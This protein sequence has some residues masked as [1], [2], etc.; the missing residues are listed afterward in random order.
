[1]GQGASHEEHFPVASSDGQ[2]MGCC[3]SSERTQSVADLTG[4]AEFG[5]SS[6]SSACRPP[7]AEHGVVR[8]TKADAPTLPASALPIRPESAACSF[9]AATDFGDGEDRHLLQGIHLERSQFLRLPDSAPLRVRVGSVEVIDRFL[10]SN[11]EVACEIRLY[12]PRNALMIALFPETSYA[13]VKQTAPAKGETKGFGRSTWLFEEELAFE[14]EAVGEERRV[15][16]GLQAQV[17]L[18]DC[19]SGTRLAASSLFKVPTDS[20]QFE[21]LW[22]KATF[23]SRRIGQVS[24]ASGWIGTEMVGW[25]SQEVLRRASLGNWDWVSETVHAMSSQE[26][27]DMVESSCDAARRRI[28]DYAAMS[29]MA[30]PQAKHVFNQLLKAG[31]S[32]EG[33]ADLEGL[34]ALHYASFAG[35]CDAVE[36]LLAARAQPEVAAAGGVTPLMLAALAGSLPCARSLLEAG[37]SIAAVDDEGQTAVTWVCLGCG[38]PPSRSG[39]NRFLNNGPEEVKAMA[40][41][42]GGLHEALD[43]RRSRGGTEP[44]G[45]PDR[46]ELLGE[47]I[48]SFC[49]SAAFEGASSPSGAA[50]AR[51]WLPLLRE[52]S[53]PGPVR[54]G[55]FS[56]V[57]GKLQKNPGLYVPL[58]GGVLRASIEEGRHWGE[59]LCRMLLREA[60]ELPVSGRLS[61]G[62]PLV[63]TAFDLG[64]DEVALMLCDRGASLDINLTAQARALRAAVDSGHREIA[65]EIVG[66]WAEERDAW[67]RPA[68]PEQEGLAECPVCFRALCEAGPAVLFSSAGRR[69]CGHF[70]CCTCAAE[71]SIQSSSPRCPV[72]RQPFQPPVQRPPDPREDPA[73]WFAFFD[74]AQTGYLD[75]QLLERVLPAVV[76]VDAEQLEASLHGELWHEWDPSGEGRV[77]RRAFCGEKGL[78]RWLVEH[79]EELQQ[80][81]EK[82]PLPR[83]EV[84][85]EGWFL[86]WASAGTKLMGKAEVLRAVL[87]SCGTSSLEASAVAASREWIERCWLLW[88]RDGSGKISLKEFCAEGGLADMMLQ[89]SSLAAAKRVVRRMELETHDPAALVACCQHLVELAVGIRPEDPVDSWVAAAC[90]RL[91]ERASQPA[92]EEFEA[93]LQRGSE[94]VVL[95]MT[96]NTSSA[97]LFAWGCRALTA[98]CLPPPSSFEDKPNEPHL[99]DSKHGNSLNGS[100]GNSCDGNHLALDKLFAI[101]RTDIPEKV[102]SRSSFVLKGFLALLPKDDR[103]TSTAPPPIAPGA[104]REAGLCALAA[105]RA[106]CDREG[107]ASVTQVCQELISVLQDGDSGTAA[108]VS[109]IAA[110]IAV[111]AMDGQSLCEMMLQSMHDAFPTGEGHSRTRA[112]SLLP[113]LRGL[114]TAVAEGLKR[115][116]SRLPTAAVA[117]ELTAALLASL[118]T[119]PAAARNGAGGGASMPSSKSRVTLRDGHVAVGDVVRLHSDVERV[120]REQEPPEH[121]GGWCDRMAFCLESPGRVVEI[122]KRSARLPE[123]LRISH[124]ALGCW[125]WNAK[126]VAE[127]LP[128]AGLLPFEECDTGPGAALTIGDEVRI[129]VTVEEAKT[130]QVNHGGWNDRMSQCCGRVGRLEAIDKAGDMKVLVPGAGSFVWNPAALRSLHAQ[131][132]DLAL[133]ERLS[134][135]IEG[136]LPLTLL[137]AL[138]GLGCRLDDAGLQAALHELALEASVTQDGGFRGWTLL[139]TAALTI[140]PAMASYSLKSVPSPDK[141]TAQQHRPV[142]SVLRKEGNAQHL[143]QGE[144]IPP[145]GER[146][147]SELLQKWWEELPSWERRAR[148]V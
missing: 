54:C 133:V 105:L 98:L 2:A 110:A 122:P 96:R 123:V 5:T 57:Y 66:Q 100:G 64:W 112:V 111:L 21:P 47:L 7:K 101:I 118:R 18:I 132:W 74:E 109:W 104:L 142:R 72:C 23:T 37:A 86:H 89:Q 9:Q 77:S 144:A 61:D 45:G 141:D 95:A 63:E 92:H 145:F 13:E 12:A 106:L 1:M 20:E 138:A 117:A 80:E 28:L 26:L 103:G 11:A 29:V 65:K 50:A 126:S 46:R 75:R 41:I 40:G 8:P 131:R 42:S 116:P 39:R 19:V 102:D 4:V 55:C 119:L 15:D 48:D 107:P 30:E 10:E 121:F 79:F 84:D 25:L 6:S 83:L 14:G 81:Q 148:A 120:K 24:V 129:E 147:L 130:L 27:R 22:S 143:L 128:D 146:S 60:P 125:C 82:G 68:A 134:G 139:A 70:L 87:K 52:A 93:V 62:R 34:T 35:S 78:L 31:V 85:R 99:E 17:L 76:P 108:H 53:K 135:S 3:S 16:G 90:G 91:R 69:S 51:R 140:D 59:Q 44:W 49:Q 36:A 67:S 136:L 71:L 56:E 124:G 97:K 32:P 33:H 94:Q 127:V 38:E 115:P 43:R 58:M 73:A 88:D 113:S 114:L 137:A